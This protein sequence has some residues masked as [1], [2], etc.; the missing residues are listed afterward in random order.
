MKKHNQFSKVHVSRVPRS[1]WD[2]SH[3]FL[4]TG[5]FGQIQPVDWEA[6]QP[7][8]DYSIR[9][10]SKMLSVPYF[11]PM[12]SRIHNKTRYFAVPVRKL[13]PYWDKFCTQLPDDGIVEPYTTLGDVFISAYHGSNPLSTGNLIVQQAM[14]PGGLGDMMGWPWFLDQLHI[15]MLS[16]LDIQ[17]YQQL[18]AGNPAVTDVWS[19][20]VW[21]KIIL[22]LN[23]VAD[24]FPS[25]EAFLDLHEQFSFSV[26]RS[27]LAIRISRCGE[28]SVRWIWCLS[29]RS[30][31]DCCLSS[32][33]RRSS[34]IGSL[35]FASL[36]TSS[37]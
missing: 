16:G 21:S 23:D 6:L 8:E 22:E 35:I 9:E 7:G 10:G 19:E 14:Q 28:R 1:A 30:D 25:F 17:A 13:V 26:T 34:S 29:S 33:I 2:K 32:P 20:Q 37:H 5:H 31:C 27:T 15:I 4:Y 18:L 24:N 12:F 11:A 36:M 3:E